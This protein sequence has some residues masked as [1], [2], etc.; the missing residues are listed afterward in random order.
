MSLPRSSL[1]CLLLA[2]TLVAFA[3]GVR[4]E[5]APPTPPVS[6]APA[7]GP[8]PSAVSRLSP[9]ELEFLRRRLP[10]FDRRDEAERERIATNVI[11]LRSLSPEDRKRFI[12]RVHRVEAEGGPGAAATADRLA[13]IEKVGRAS[14]REGSLRMRAVATAV[15]ATLSPERRAVL[16]PNAAPS[17]IGSYERLQLDVCIAATWKRRVMES[18]ATKPL[19]AAEPLSAAGTPAAVAFVTL[20]DRV[21]TGGAAAPEADRRKYAMAYLEDRVQ[22]AR[23]GLE[24]SN[25]VTT[26]GPARG[27]DSRLAAFGAALSEAFPSSIAATAAE[28][29][30][31]V[32]GGR[33][34][35]KKFCDDAWPDR[36]TPRERT[37]VELVLGLERARPFL[38]GD[39]LGKLCDL[40]IAAL[41]ELKVADA[42]LLKFQP[43][44]DE[45]PRLLV[46]APLA[47]RLRN[48]DRGGPHAGLGPRFG[49][50]R[51][52]K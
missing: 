5:D 21:K 1:R 33:A 9:Q 52:D 31:A 43:G 20:R 26:P 2:T 10:D 16:T 49:G 25:P 23:R 35:L 50:G 14:F 29:A 24:G 41:R 17:S 34:A 3:P 12:E 36:A 45:P 51:R 30:T 19:V 32:D 27:E 13:Q 48:A 4:A 47:R 28:L 46:L 11:R 22:A 15:V 40:Q 42:D 7:A 38:A 6:P 44:G 37:L 8:T 18:L 39:L